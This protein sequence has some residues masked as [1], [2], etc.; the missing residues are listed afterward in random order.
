VV[1]VYKDGSKQKKKLVRLFTYLV[2]WNFLFLLASQLS[3][4][5]PTSLSAWVFLGSFA[6]VPKESRRHLPVLRS[7]RRLTGRAWECS[8]AHRPGPSQHGFSPALLPL[9]LFSHLPVSL[10]HLHLVINCIHPLHTCHTASS[11]L[12]SE[13]MRTRGWQSFGHTLGF[14]SERLLVLW[15]MEG[16][17]PST[18]ACSY[19]AGPSSP[20]GRVPQ[21]F[22]LRGVGP[23]PVSTHDPYW[24]SAGSS[25]GECR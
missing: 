4:H 24:G 8:H 2:V 25:F 15:H 16:D 17:G 21:A 19:T 1:L 12:L 14:L 13:Q 9:F 18:R 11:F 7:S 3:V 20:A 22:H 23:L 10:S 6:S 5:P